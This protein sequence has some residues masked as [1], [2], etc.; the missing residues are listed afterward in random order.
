MIKK[1]FDPGNNSYVVNAS[2]L[3]LRIWVGLT[4]LINHGAD[5]LKHFSDIAPNFP[6]P[7]GIGHPASLALAVFAEFFVSLFVVFGLVTRWSALVLAINMSVAFIGV[8]KGVLSGQESGELAFLY[9]M[10][11]AVLL[12]AGPGSFSVDKVVFGQRGSESSK[13]F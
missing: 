8:H 11:Y 2:L 4:M 5:K 13:Q 12:L 1:I 6:D 3:A 9:L 10:G 7:L